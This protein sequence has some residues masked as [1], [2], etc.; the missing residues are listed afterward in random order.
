VHRSER[1][2]ER[3]R[4]ELERAGISARYRF[5]RQPEGAERAAPAGGA[6]AVR[7]PARRMALVDGAWI[8]VPPRAGLRGM[9]ALLSELPD[10]VYSGLRTFPV[11]RF[12]GLTAH[13]DRAERSARALGYS[14]QAERDA[15]LRG[16]QRVADE[17]AP[18]DLA[19]RFDVLPAPTEVE[20]V[21]A[22]LWIGAAALEPVPQRFLDEGVGV[23]WTRE[24]ARER[25]LVKTTAFVRQRHP[26]PLARQDA[27]EHVMLDAEGRVLEGTSSNFFAVR[28]DRLLTAGGGVLEGITRAIV[29]DLAA[30]RGMRIELD[31]PPSSQAATWSEAFLT[32]S[33]RGVVP[34]VACGGARVGAGKPGPHTRALLD[35]YSDYAEREARRAC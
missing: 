13:L 5:R 33:T 7:A 6:A 28:G 26:Y 12:L 2:C 23:Q 25:P 9:H 20:G 27:Y 32:S 4:S 8:D 19:L 17:A 21:R 16:L 35:A 1:S 31:A 3:H 30:R 24:L 10:G 11:A 15:L 18:V 22:R 14:F 34:I 29:L